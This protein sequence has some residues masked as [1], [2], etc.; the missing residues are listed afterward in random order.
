MMVAWF[1]VDIGSCRELTSAAVVV[2]VVVNKASGTAVENPS[3]NIIH[4]STLVLNFN[5]FHKAPSLSALLFFGVI[6]FLVL[7]VLS[8]K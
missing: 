1:Y 5:T 4:F 7:L 8:C 2:M 6:I 3:C